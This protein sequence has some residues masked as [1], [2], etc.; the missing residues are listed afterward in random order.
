[1]AQMSLGAPSRSK[2][3]QFD[4]MLDAAFT[5]VNVIKLDTQRDDVS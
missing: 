5:Q 1:M 4:S 2:K 3:I